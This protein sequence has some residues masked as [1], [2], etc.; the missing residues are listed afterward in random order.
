M[1][2]VS[3]ALSNLTPDLERFFL[4]SEEWIFLEEWDD[5]LTDIVNAAD[6]ELDVWTSILHRVFTIPAEVKVIDATASE[7]RLNC[8]KDLAIVFP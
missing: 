3:N 5:F 1:L 6:S 2:F 7:V 8:L 4:S